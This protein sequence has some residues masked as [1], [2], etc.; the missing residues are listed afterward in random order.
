MI[1]D[2]SRSKHKQY[3]SGN[4][5]AQ[6]TDGGT[7]T[8][9]VVLPSPK[10]RSRNRVYFLQR[11]HFDYDQQREKA[12]QGAPYLILG[13][14][15][16]P[17]AV[18][19]Q[20]D[21]LFRNRQLPERPLPP[22]TAIVKVFDDAAQSLLILGEP[23]AGKSLLLLDLAQKL[24]ER[25]EQDE[26]FPMPVILPLSNWAVRRPPLAEWMSDQLTRFYDVSPQISAGWVSTRQVLP[27]LDGLDEVTRDARTACIVA[28]NDY[29]KNFAG[30]LV[31]CCRLAEYEEIGQGQRLTLSNAITLQPLNKEQ[32]ATYLGSH[33]DAFRTFLQVNPLMQDMLTSPLM[34]H[35]LTLAY[36]GTSQQAFL[37]QGTPE[38][39]QRTIFATYVERMVERK[40]K[41]AHYPLQRTVIWLHWLARQMENRKE[42]IFNLEQLQPDWLPENQN[43]LYRWCIR[44]MSG[45]IGMFI[46]GLLLGVLGGFVEGFPHGVFSVLPL[47]LLGGLPGGLAWGGRLDT[48]TKP[49]SPLKWAWKGIR[50]GF[51]GGLLVFVCLFVVSLAA[52]KEALP[53][54]LETGF[55]DGLFAGL[56][57]GLV[58]GLFVGQTWGNQ[59][60]ARIEPVEVLTWSWKG[61]RSALFGGFLSGLLFGLLFAPLFA[62]ISLQVTGSNLG[63]FPLLFGVSLFAL[64]FGFLV[65]LPFALF[66]G[67]VG[68]FAGLQLADRRT[69]RP[70]EGIRRSTR[71]GLVSGGI[72][73][74][75]LLTF[76]FLSWIS[77]G[78]LN[79]L[80]VALLLGTGVA[81]AVGLV[82]GL[83]A[84][85][86]QA[87]LCFCLWRTHTFPLRPVR[88]FNDATERVLL[89][90]VGGGYSFFH[91]FI[92]EYFLSR[93][94]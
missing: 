76:G 7:A 51:A 34:L 47:G 74:I 81:L 11:L 6:A 94:H 32:V 53:T 91:R 42:T 39:Q 71:H 23:G 57:A 55:L 26:E 46:G 19:H 52:L 43:T 37:H 84:T 68:G 75:G 35:V 16:K 73:G 72:A 20:T 54:A 67:L 8:I 83:T 27:L 38:E 12:L 90:R 82:A 21:L 15:E 9:N 1:E 48:N 36:A 80:V 56:P 59:W 79:G 49:F 40:G 65:G 85:L 78:S 88:F 87:L 50:S 24:V 31:V 4:Y 41:I 92:F 69:L 28:I 14:N 30:P 44:L 89:R 45:L 22:E 60:N 77:F 29:Y 18:Q 63:L 86:K 62:L 33:L 25:A 66:G 3:A 2:D 10:L 13:L 58:A 5:I 61:A 93:D 17:S 64:L 70:N